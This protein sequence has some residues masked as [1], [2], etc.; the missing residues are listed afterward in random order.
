MTLNHEDEALSELTRLRAENTR[1]ITLLETHGIDWRIPA[2]EPA[3]P[4]ARL[5]TQDK[6]TLFRTRFRGR[7]DTYP[8]RW[9]SRTTSKSGYAPA[10]D[11][12]W[13]P[14]ICE[15]PR[16]KCADCRHRVLKPLTDQVL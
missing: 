10:C 15:K 13:R 16:I 12:E 8:V 5:S 11:N 9:E 14:G 2:P 1:L 6:L 4:P 7:E 3:P